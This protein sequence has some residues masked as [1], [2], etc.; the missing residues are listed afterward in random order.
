MLMVS[1]NMLAPGNLTTIKRDEIEEMF[2]SKTSMMPN[3]LLN[4]LTQDEILDL[5][6]YL[7][8]GGS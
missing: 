7:R 4:N 1:E 3:G 6:A 5:I 8:A 2:T